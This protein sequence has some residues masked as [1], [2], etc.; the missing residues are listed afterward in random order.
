[1]TYF[2]KVNGV[3]VGTGYYDVCRSYVIVCDR[4][5]INAWVYVACCS[6]RMHCCWRLRRTDYAFSVHP[7]STSGVDFIDLLTSNAFRYN[8]FPLHAYI[9][10]HRVAEFS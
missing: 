6:C 3:I 7:I 9:V 4:Q 10:N 1:M 5:L 2:A 8:L